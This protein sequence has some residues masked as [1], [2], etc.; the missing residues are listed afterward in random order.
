MPAFRGSFDDLL[1]PGAYAVY[2]D[3]YEQLPA[4]YP[5]LV[6]VETTERAFEEAIITSGLGTTPQK[7][8]GQDVAVDRP[9]PVGKVRMAVIS[10]GLGYEVTHEMWQDDLYHAVA[11]PSS[12]FL[13]QSGRDTEE[14]MAFAM[15]NTAFT[16]QEAWDGVSLINDAHPTV[17]GS[18]QANRPNPDA[19]LGIASIQ[20]S[21]ERFRLLKN[22]RGLHI[23]MVPAN[24]LVPTQ[25]EWLA[26]EILGSPHKP[27]TAD[28]TINV[29]AGGRIG[30]TRKTGTYLTST[31]AWYIT[32][33]K[34]KH[35]LKFFWREKPNMDRDFDKKARIAIFMNFFRFGTASFDWRGID[36]STG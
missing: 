36:G 1:A 15:Y 35:K 11:D 8:E 32:V 21:I 26:D 2:S 27:F 9:L 33:D 28:N 16:T 13:A 18:T 17:D 24:L 30:L 23:R 12:R 3:E 22:E 20:A 19:A 25:L 4:E 10:Y 5:D 6:N 7:P 31:T 29:T 34:S 14:R